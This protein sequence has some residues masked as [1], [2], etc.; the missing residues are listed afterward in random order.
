M[1]LQKFACIVTKEFLCFLR[2]SQMSKMV[3]ISKGFWD[4]PWPRPGKDQVSIHG[5]EGVGD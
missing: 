1:I 3:I 4:D 5:V 2:C